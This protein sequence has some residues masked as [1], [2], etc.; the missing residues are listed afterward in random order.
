MMARSHISQSFIIILSS[1]RYVLNNVEREVKHQVIIV[2]VRMLLFAYTEEKK[3]QENTNVLFS[4]LK[5]LTL[6]KV[7]VWEVT[8]T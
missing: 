3:L 8:P 4:C 5:N 7:T 6:R 2:I 1:S